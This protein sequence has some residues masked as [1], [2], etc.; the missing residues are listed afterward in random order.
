MGVM[1]DKILDDFRED[2]P[3]DL[4]GYVKKAADVV[5]L[6]PDA[7]EPALDDYGIYSHA[8]SSAPIYTLPIPSNTSVTHE[9]VIEVAFSASALSAAFVDSLGTPIPVM[10]M[11]G[12]ISAGVVVVFLCR[13]SAGLDKWVIMPVMME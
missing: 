7:V 6:D 9:I 5:A 1:F 10:D 12:T 2:N 8:P 11:A 13:W 4:S 3:V